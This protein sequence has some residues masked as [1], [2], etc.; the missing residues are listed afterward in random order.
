MRTNELKFNPDKMEIL[1]IQKVV[2]QVLDP[3]FA[4]DGIALPLKEQVCVL[5]ILL[6]CPWTVPGHPGGICEQKGSCSAL[7]GAPAVLFL[8]Q[9]HLTTVIYTLMTPWLDSIMHSSWGYTCRQ[10]GN[11]SWCRMQWFHWSLR[12]GVHNLLCYCSSSYTNCLFLVN[13]E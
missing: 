12:L 8:C 13:W 11:C 7:A 9:W 6:D 10:F 5:G 1:L 2:M 4:L 3:Q